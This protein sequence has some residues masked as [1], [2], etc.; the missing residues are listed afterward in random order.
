MPAGFW[1]GCL[2][3]VLCLTGHQI[4]VLIPGYL[5]SHGMERWE[6]GLAEG[7][8][9]LAA[10]LVQPLIGARID[11]GGPRPFIIRGAIAM[12]ALAALFLVVPVKLWA[13]LPIRFAQGAAAAV[14]LTAAYTWAASLGTEDQLVRVFGFYG[15]S[16]LIPNAIGPGLGA[17]AH[18]S[19]GYPATFLLVAAF[20]LVAALCAFSMV[21]VGPGVRRGAVSF[22]AAVRNP[23]LYS[24]SA[25]ALCFGLLT[26][27]LTAFLGPYLIHEQATGLAAYWAVYT[28]FSVG[29]RILGMPLFERRGPER[30]VV[31][32][33]LLMGAGVLLV[34]GS[35]TLPALVL[36]ASTTGSGHGMLFPAFNALAVRR[37]GPGTRGVAMALV[38]AAV[39][40]GSAVGNPVIGGIAH[41]AGYRAMYMVVAMGAV[42]MA[43][44]FPV[45]ERLRA[46]AVALLVLCLAGAA[47]A[48]RIAVLSDVEGSAL[49][50]ERFLSKHPAFEPGPGGRVKLAKDAYFVHGGDVPDRFAGSGEVVA[51]L[52][53]LSRAHP[54]RVVL[55]AGNRDVNKLRIA[56]ELSPEALRHD[57]PVRVSDWAKWLP[58]HGGAAKAHD[59]ATR[60]K[61][62][63]ERTMGAPDA[64]ELRR[65]DL[66][67]FAGDVVS[68]DAVAASFVREYGPDGPFREMLGRS[69]L[70]ARIGNTVFCHA[71]LTAENLGAVPGSAGLAG[72]V[73]DWIAGLDR[74]YRAELAAWDAQA[75]SWSGTGPR[76]AQALIRYAEPTDAGAPNQTSVVYSRNADEQG[77]IALPPDEVIRWLAASGVRRLVIGHTPSGEVPVPLR[78]EDGAFECL[79]VDTSRA[80]DSEMPTYTTLEGHDF[81]WTAVTGSLSVAGAR[82]AVRYRARIGAASKLGT[83]TP[84][85]Q[86]LVAPVERGW[87]GYQLEPGWKVVYRLNEPA[88]APTADLELR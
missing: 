37:L 69:K 49:K 30:M 51:E 2:V 32:P 62:I 11:R 35:S 50:L 23:E 31:V 53:R 60:L 22:G 87:I 3:N 84:D 43:M 73:D 86:V 19:Q 80:P 9:W 82:Q 1:W 59:R 56:A 21:D 8:F 27:S 61:W 36:A 40:L 26:G 7:A 65:K 57:P 14:Y 38:N 76:P 74:W 34:A 17:A 4:G 28:A 42:L 55:I 18:A 64:F 88:I 5:A 12:G 79:V 16:G 66:A 6:L 13:V 10:L 20:E 48:D 24:A 67:T 85:G 15:I 46:P 41:V 70:L 81:E 25:T 39:Y 83:R 77:K 29:V 78:T 44:A 68:D 71:G 72:N 45:I 52:L 47:H 75:A 58:E 33:I 54:E 63:L